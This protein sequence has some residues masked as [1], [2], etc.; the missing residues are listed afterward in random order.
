[1]GSMGS[2][3][4]TRSR[5]ASTKCYI[6]TCIHASLVQRF[7]E[8]EWAGFIFLNRFLQ[9]RTDLLLKLVRDD[10]EAVDRGLVV[11]DPGVLH[12][13]AASEVVEVIARIRLV[14]HVEKQFRGCESNST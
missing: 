8:R 2:L 14:I 1:M 5:S 4:G 12:E 11:G 10:G 9:Q 3:E 7:S 13:G 6:L